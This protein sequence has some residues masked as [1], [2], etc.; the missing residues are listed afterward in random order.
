MITKRGMAIMVSPVI[1]L[2]V[3]IP[4][5][6]SLPKPSIK[7]ETIMLTTP[8]AMKT[9]TPKANST[10]SPPNNIMVASSALIRSPPEDQSLAFC[11]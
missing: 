7:M 11:L 4:T 5:T 1:T 10:S 3:V 9:R 2:K 8:R 6:P